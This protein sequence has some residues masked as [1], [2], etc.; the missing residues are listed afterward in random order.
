MPHKLDE[1]LK[2]IKEKIDA[3]KDCAVL[4]CGG[5]A[6]NGSVETQIF[7]LG[8]WQKNKGFARC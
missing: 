8:V 6:R 7:D 4:A 2:K 1:G 5:D 3:G